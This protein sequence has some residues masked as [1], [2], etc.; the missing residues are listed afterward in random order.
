MSVL[1]LYRTCRRA[2]PIAAVHEP[3]GGEMAGQLREEIGVHATAR[4]GPKPCLDIFHLLV[5]R[6][7]F[8]SSQLLMHRPTCC[9]VEPWLKISFRT[10]HLVL[11]NWPRLFLATGTGL[12]N[13]RLHEVASA[14]AAV[15]A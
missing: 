3:L 9:Q 2:L 13:A 14:I 7:A 4:R 15:A 6:Y 8:Y 5:M 10:E 12:S 11:E 1:D